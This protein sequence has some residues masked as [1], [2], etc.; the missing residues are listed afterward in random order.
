V[1]LKVPASVYKN[2]FHYFRVDQLQGCQMVYFKTKTPIWVNFEGPKNTK[3]RYILWSCRIFHGHWYILWPFGNVV[4]IWYVLPRFG[5]LYHEE[6]GN[7]DQLTFLAI[8]ACLAFSAEY[9]DNKL[10]KSKFL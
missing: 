7:P 9:R 5:I 3:C 1:D 8:G 6:S 2:V 10:E 4:I